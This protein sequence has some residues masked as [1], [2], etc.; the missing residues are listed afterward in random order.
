MINCSNCGTPFDPATD[1]LHITS[2]KALVAAICGECCKD[3][4]VAKIALRRPEVG[5]FQYEQW[6]PVEVMRGGLT[7]PQAR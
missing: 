2:R 3:V 4:R 5:T 7:S 1:G 6:S